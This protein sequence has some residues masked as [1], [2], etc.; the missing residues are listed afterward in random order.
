LKR[1]FKHF[2][3]LYKENPTEKAVL[4]THLLAVVENKDA[5]GGLLPLIPQ[6]IDRMLKTT[7][8]ESV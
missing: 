4:N 5:D 7:Y 1:G 3:T 8:P 6:R 2:S